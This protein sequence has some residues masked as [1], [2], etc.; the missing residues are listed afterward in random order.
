MSQTERLL[1]VNADDLGLA[2]GVTRGILELARSKAVTS[3]NLLVNLPGSGD[4]CAMARSMGID[5]GLSVLCW[6][7]R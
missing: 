3:A 6:I 7:G 4:A 5:A 2:P 1:I